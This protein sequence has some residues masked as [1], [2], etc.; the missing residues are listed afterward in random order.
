MNNQEYQQAYWLKNK[1]RLHAKHKEWIKNNPEKVKEMRA[2]YREA[3]K[4]K[5]TMW[6]KNYEQRQRDI[7]GGKEKV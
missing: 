4:E 3:N 2:K 6:R 5:I 7:K 1:E